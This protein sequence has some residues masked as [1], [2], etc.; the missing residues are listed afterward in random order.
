MI[1][2]HDKNTSC[3]SYNKIQILKNHSNR[4]LTE[5]LDI[6][7]LIFVEFCT[8]RTM[9]IITEYLNRELNVIGH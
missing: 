9:K 1:S 7:I 3:F 2:F 6:R 4:S 8:L 5:Y